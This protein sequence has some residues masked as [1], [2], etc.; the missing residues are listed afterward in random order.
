MKNS[1]EMKLEMLRSQ[2]RKIIEKGKTTVETGDKLSKI[3]NEIKLLKAQLR[4]GE[5]E[6]RISF[7]KLIEEARNSDEELEALEK[8]DISSGFIKSSAET[9]PLRREEIENQDKLLRS[10]LTEER[11]DI[12]KPLS[13]IQ[14]SGQ[15]NDYLNIISHQIKIFELSQGRVNELAIRV[16]QNEVG[17]S[18]STPIGTD[19]IQSCIVLIIRDPISKK[20][21]LA[22]ISN[23]TEIGSIRKIFQ[24]LPNNEVEIGIIGGR[25]EHQIKE[26]VDANVKKI[27]SILKE[28]T[29]SK[30]IYIEAKAM[31]KEIN[32]TKCQALTFDP[33]IK[34]WRQA[35][36]AEV[37]GRALPDRWL[38]EGIVESFAEE[39]PLN[40]AF[41]FMENKEI[42]LPVK[43]TREAIQQNLSLYYMTPLKEF[44][45]NILADRGEY[46]LSRTIKGIIEL[47]KE[48]KIVTD[49]TIA[50]AWPE[51]MAVSQ[52]LLNL[53]EEK[54][55]MC[56]KLLGKDWKEDNI[57]LI[58]LVGN[59]MRGELE[60]QI[61]DEFKLMSQEE[62]FI[63]RTINRTISTPEEE[64]REKESMIGKRKKVQLSCKE[65][66]VSGKERDEDED[67]EHKKDH[68]QDKRSKSE[69]KHLSR[70]D[71][72][73][74][75]KE[76]A[77]G[78][79]NSFS[80]DNTKTKKSFCSKVA[81]S[82]TKGIAR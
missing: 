28:L 52:E 12:T 17:F 26:E 4:E 36:K 1:T 54:V 71:Q 13:Q 79:V 25:R 37:P 81:N 60:V 63:E 40:I 49:K 56:P 33:S 35:L 6:V 19:N 14:R 27:L 22:H 34:D 24:H 30:V 5:P 61:L 2:K 32:S 42:I 75:Q 41:D 77:S 45:E 18:D 38:R 31:G 69:Q 29:G 70:S 53:L 59:V 46:I 50:E 8:A 55:I 15:I 9:S 72:Q 48:N 66:A 11:I 58:N 23:A 39:I 47:V 78:Q 64:Q 21:A 20:T 44:S 51:G 74:E 73:Q 57:E 7:D 16:E 65:E 3:K 62:K 68:R 67:E 76:G 82:L 10:L 43:L 80:T